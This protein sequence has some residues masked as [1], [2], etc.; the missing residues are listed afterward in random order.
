MKLITLKQAED[1]NPTVNWTHLKVGQQIVI[2]H[3]PD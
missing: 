3:P 1:A 2:P